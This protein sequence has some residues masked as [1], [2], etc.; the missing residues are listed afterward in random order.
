M[1]GYR[2]SSSYIGIKGKIEWIER[3]GSGQVSQV[4]ASTVLSAVKSVYTRT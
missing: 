2:Y 3:C 4:S 1:V